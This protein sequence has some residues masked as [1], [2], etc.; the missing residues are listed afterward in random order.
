MSKICRACTLELP[1]ESFY[2]NRRKCKACYLSRKPAA[3][4]TIPAAKPAIISPAIQALEKAFTRAFALTCETRC[5]ALSCEPKTDREEYVLRAALFQSHFM[6]LYAEFLPAPPKPAAV[7]P[8][9]AAQPT[10]V[11][12]KSTIKE[13]PPKPLAA[14]PTIAAQKS[15]TKEEP[16]K[17]AAVQPTIAVQKSVTKE[18]PPKPAAV[19]PTI[20]SPN[21]VPQ[22][23]AAKKKTNKN[24]IYL[25]HDDSGSLTYG[26]PKQVAAVRRNK[27]VEEI[28]RETYLSY[29]KENT[30][31]S[32]GD[33]VGHVTGE[34]GNILDYV[35]YANEKEKTCIMMAKAD[36]KHAEKDMDGF[37][38]KYKGSY[39]D[40]SS[41]MKVLIDFGYKECDICGNTD[42]NELVIAADEDNESENE[43]GGND[44]ELTSDEY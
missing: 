2:A 14:Q 21:A 37:V 16:P 7:Q 32:L 36:A 30:W 20:N 18:E 15:V 34:D 3:V 1:I 43:G 4:S 44:A 40:C 41:S 28:D 22:K 33:F 23:V 42:F 38:P 25:Y 11:V 24:I 5:S 8:T 27:Q 19:R 29:L 10:L 12:Q 35:L 31:A 6:K 17:P 9:I 39:D 13:E 26:F